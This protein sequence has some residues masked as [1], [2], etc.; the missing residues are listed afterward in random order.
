MNWFIIAFIAIICIL[1]I[2]KT[3]QIDYS[4]LN[5]FTFNP[6]RHDVFSYNGML[7][8]LITSEENSSERNDR[9]VIISKNSDKNE[10]Q[11]NSM[12]NV[13]MNI[14]LSR[15]KETTLETNSGIINQITKLI[16][17][18]TG[19]KSNKPIILN[20][21]WTL[22]STKSDSVNFS[23]TIN[24]INSESIS[25][26]SFE[27]ENL[28]I[29]RILKLTS[30]NNDYL[31]L[32]KIDIFDLSTKIIKNVGIFLIIHGKSINIILES[33]VMGDYYNGQP[34]YGYVIR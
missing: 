19:I 11:S 5:I 1:I 8:S 10:D 23:A 31:I 30:D 33:G 18:L 28:K 21:N 9:H 24:E 22:K 3:I 29:D 12:V 25:A 2:I 26:R 6:N 20:G 13:L 15:V 14:I 4:V 17:N 32:G 16:D 7:F 34:I 27:L